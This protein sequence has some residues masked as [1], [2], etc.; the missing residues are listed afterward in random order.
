LEFVRTD[1]LKSSY[2]TQVSPVV[3][4]IL[5]CERTVGAHGR[6]I[7]LD[8][9]VQAAYLHLFLHRRVARIVAGRIVGSWPFA[10]Y[11]GR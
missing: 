6:P 2:T 7:P 1:K 8:V 9:A 3:L 10:T 4:A 11:F 5:N